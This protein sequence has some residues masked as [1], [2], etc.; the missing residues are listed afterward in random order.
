MLLLDYLCNLFKC[1]INELEKK[2][3]Q[4]RNYL[5]NHL[6]RAG[7]IKTTHLNTNYIIDCDGFTNCNSNQI[8]T[9]LK[10]IEVSLTEYYFQ[11]YN[12]FVR[13]NLPAMKCFFLD[14]NVRYYLL[15]YLEI[16]PNNFNDFNNNSALASKNSTIKKSIKPQTSEKPKTK[17]KK[18]L[19]EKKD[20]RKKIEIIQI[21]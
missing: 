21:D 10:K 9:K 17:A 3:H 2:I 18:S 13:Y 11:I 6:R 19:K 15:E 20:I 16:I 7:D 5:I 4:N 1:N 8:K 14:G 12:I